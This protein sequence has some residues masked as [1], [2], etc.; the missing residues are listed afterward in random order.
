MKPLIGLNVK[1]VSRVQSFTKEASTSAEG[2][3]ISSV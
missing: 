2:E 3:A 1:Y